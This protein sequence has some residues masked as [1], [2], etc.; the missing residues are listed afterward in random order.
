MANGKK[1]VTIE[2]IRAIHEEHFEKNFEDKNITEMFEIFVKLIESVAITNECLQQL[3]E[4][5]NVK[6]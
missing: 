2:Q 5:K 3:E 6:K 1:T 4:K